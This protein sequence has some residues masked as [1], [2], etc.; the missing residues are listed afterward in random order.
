VI[1]RVAEFVFTL[2]MVHQFQRAIGNHFIGVHVGRRPRTALQDIEA[3][4]VVQLAVDQFLARPF[5]A[6]Q[7]RPIEDPAVSVGSSGRHLDHAER[8]NQVGIE[9]E[10]DA[11]NVKIDKRAR[12]LHA[13]VGV[14]GHSKI[15]EQIVLD[16]LSNFRHD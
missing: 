12:G 16:A 1:V 14:R 3:E 8:F 2:P 7:H 13:V 10:L 11:G 6:C 4:L 9:A 15:T 5:H